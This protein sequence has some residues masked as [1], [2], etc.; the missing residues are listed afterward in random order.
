[1]TVTALVSGGKDSIYAAYLADTQGWPVDEL[2]TIAP[3]D[4]DAMMFH[5]PN[6]DLVALQARAWRKAH[7]RVPVRGTGEERELTALRDALAGARGPVV[8]GAVESSYQWAR[9]LRVAD[10][11]GRRLYAPLWRKEPARVVREEI[12]AGLDIRL[13]H[14]AA[15][16][17]TPDL[18]GRRLDLDLLTELERRSREVRQVN[19]AGEGGEFETLVV[20]APFFEEQIDLEEVERSV[21]GS[22]ARLRVAKA[23]LVP[24]ELRP[25]SPPAR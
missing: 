12:A 14:L 20:D 5:T 6:L 21:T 8:A 24:K 16:P 10:D 7:R 15:E 22:T 1:M 13:V 18:L 19:V 25:S 4:P 17:L 3:E 2:L 23:R 11:V 9:L